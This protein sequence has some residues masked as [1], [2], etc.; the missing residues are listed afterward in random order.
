MVNEEEAMEAK[1]VHVFL[2]P[3]TFLPRLSCKIRLLKA[4]SVRKSHVT[5]RGLIRCSNIMILKK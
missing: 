5:Q 2:K 3:V 1:T 4:R